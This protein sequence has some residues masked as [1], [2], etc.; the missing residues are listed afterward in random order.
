MLS[1]L[2]FLLSA[3]QLNTYVY[4]FTLHKYICL[5]L[6]VCHLNQSIMCIPPPSRTRTL[7]LPSY[8]AGHLERSGA[9]QC[10]AALGGCGCDHLVFV[11][12][13]V[14]QPRPVSVS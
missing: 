1:S 8:E 11:L 2:V 9:M 13:W 7:C 10:G 14:L 5:N 12:Q 4:E 3:L 6:S